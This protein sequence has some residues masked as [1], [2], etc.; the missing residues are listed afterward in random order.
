MV[1]FVGSGLGFLL[2]EEDDLIDVVLKGRQSR[3][4]RSPRPG[5]SGLQ[6]AHRAPG[7][8]DEAPCTELLGV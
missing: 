1:G 3:T 4:S 5:H 8:Q 7:S 2:L 6:I